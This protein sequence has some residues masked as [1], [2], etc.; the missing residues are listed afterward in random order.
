MIFSQINSF[1]LPLSLSLSLLSI[2]MHAFGIQNKMSA[3][4]VTILS[5]LSIPGLSRLLIYSFD[6][7]VPFSL[8][9][10]IFAFIIIIILIY[11]WGHL[12]YVYMYYIDFY[13][14]AIYWYSLFFVLF[15]TEV[16]T[17]LLSNLLFFFSSLPISI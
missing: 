5:L 11:M 9:R 4:D 13:F 10:L 15:V 6:L 12:Y 2:F 14:D 1:F 7:F 8:Y 3:R 17:I 16:F